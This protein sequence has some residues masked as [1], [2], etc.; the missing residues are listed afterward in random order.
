[1]A[2]Y[3]G[4]DRDR[5]ACNGLEETFVNIGMHVPKSGEVS[6]PHQG[7]KPQKGG[8]RNHQ[9][10]QNRFGGAFSAEVIAEIAAQAAVAAVERTRK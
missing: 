7:R 6:K 5:V 3:P 2:W 8:Q 9:Q 10:K 4:L 1:M